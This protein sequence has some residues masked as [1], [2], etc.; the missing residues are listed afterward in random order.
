MRPKLLLSTVGLG[1]LLS[2]AT[3]KSQEKI[4]NYAS[5]KREVAAKTIDVGKS[6][7][8]TAPICADSLKNWPVW[9]KAPVDSLYLEMMRSAFIDE[10][11][12]IRLESGQSP[13]VSER[14]F[15]R[16]AQK[17]ADTL[18]LLPD[19]QIS[20]DVT[21]QAER[22]SWLLPFAKSVR[23]CIHRG[24]VFTSISDTSAILSEIRQSARRLMNSQK[25]AKAILNP[26]PGHGLGGVGIVFCQTPNS[27]GYRLLIVYTRGCHPIQPLNA[28]AIAGP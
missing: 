25:H 10:I 18:A 3:L 4:F 23:E 26:S 13:V 28:G 16:H 22:L 15:T 1:L 21:G 12:K 17:Y 2:T 27:S 20:H 11:S 14:H 24:S 9:S 7:L 5:D 19:S 8:F 6:K